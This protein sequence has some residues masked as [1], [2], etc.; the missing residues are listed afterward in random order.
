[1][2]VAYGVHPPFPAAALRTGVAQLSGGQS[3]VTRVIRLE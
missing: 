3:E 2:D 1:M